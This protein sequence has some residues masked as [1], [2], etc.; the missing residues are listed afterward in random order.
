LQ[1]NPGQTAEIEVKPQVTFQGRRLAIA[2]SLARYF[3]VLDI[4]VGKDSQLAATGNMGAECFSSLAVDVKME[5]DIAE[6]GIVIT[7]LVQNIDTAPQDFKAVL[8]GVV[9]ET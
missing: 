6:P 7:L 4:K 5:L 1:V 9:Y 3:D 8:Y 2:A